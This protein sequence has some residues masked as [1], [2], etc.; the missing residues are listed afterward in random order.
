MCVC[1]CVCVLLS[2]HRRRRRHR[3]RR[4]FLE[5]NRSIVSQSTS[6]P[7]PPASTVS[8][9]QLSSTTEMWENLGIISYST[10]VA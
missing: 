6:P 4:V 8:H 7:L 3:S 2:L 9:S 10:F 1:V 5:Q